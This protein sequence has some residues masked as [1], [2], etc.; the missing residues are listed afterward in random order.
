MLL[1]AVDTVDTITPEKFKKEY[2]GKGKPLVIKNLAL[3][4][5]AYTKWNWDYFKQIVGNKQVG[6]YNNAKSDA[7]T[8]V[9]RADDYTSFGE[10]IEMIR[11]GQEPAGGFSSSTFL[12]M[13]RSLFMILSGLMS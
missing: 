13:L 6:I 7:Y 3:Q 4:W 9:N 8:P 10:Y 1:K 11:K 5:P 2:Y 12:T